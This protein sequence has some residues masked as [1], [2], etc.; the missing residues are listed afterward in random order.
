MT[1]N[2]VA[3][4]ASCLL[5]VTFT[6]SQT[7]TRNGVLSV[8]STATSLPLTVQLSGIGVQPQLAVAPA[9]LNFGSVLLGKSQT[10][11]LTLSNVSTTA[12]NALQIGISAGDF[13]ATA[14]CGPVTLTAGSSCSLNVTF[15]P[16]Q[17]GTRT[18]ALTITSSDPA[19]PLTVALTGNGLQ[20]GSF[21]LTVNGASSGSATVP[22]G[23]PATYALALTPV[24]GFTG[25]VALTCTPN[26]VVEYTACSITPSTLTLTNGTVTAT[27]T[28]TTVTAVESAELR[29]D[30][31]W[32]EAFLCAA[33]MLLL[34]G[35]RRRNWKAG[36]LL[37]AGSCALRLN[38][39]C[40][41]GV[42]G[43]TRIRYA[44]PGTYRFTITAAST[45]GVTAQQS[46][47]VS[48]TITNSPQ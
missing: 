43:D 37:A 4:G 19:S 39:G 11:A 35:L 41:S 30:K 22:Y 20:A 38:G 13:S 36:L 15:A 46:V 7:G 1:G 47:P 6:P 33:P 18:G 25:A 28:I 16:T 17:P 5:P 8:S 40:G 3:P 14:T 42:K 29:R 9:T 10:L 27:A 45:T 34:A 24:N 2:A 48:L 23:I 44:A 21:T 12:V 32:R 26:A 31:G